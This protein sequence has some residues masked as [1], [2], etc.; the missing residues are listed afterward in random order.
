MVNGTPQKPIE[1][2]SMVYTF[3]KKNANA[4][5]NHKTQYFEMFGNHALYHDGWIICTT[6][7][8]TPW[9][10]TA[11][12]TQDPANA[13]KWELYDLT[14]DWTEYDNIA[15][16]NPEK[17][18]DLQEM[19]WV[20]AAKYQVL[21]LD[22]SKSARLLTPRPSADAGRTDYNYTGVI[23]GIPPSNAPDILNK[24]YTITADFEV[25]NEGGEGMLIRLGGRF[26]GWAL[27][28]LK[29][30]P[31]FL[32]NYVDLDRTRWEGKDSLAPGKHTLVFDFKYDGGGLGK[33]GLGVL[34][35]DGKE[36][37]N[38]R[39]ERSVPYTFNLD[40]DMDIGA[41]LAESISN[42]F[43]AP[44]RFNGKINKVNVKLIPAEPLGK[45]DQK[46]VADANKKIADATE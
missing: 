37:A 26:G 45:D 19:F 15:A 3:D 14:K 35:V 25:P 18:K 31:V 8:N 39:M 46:K 34:K 32:Y 23:T 17:L 1:G 6:P 10:V 30:K 43:K 2:F 20:E 40:E 29:G 24:S 44:F 28:L 16:K 9:D 41:S 42:D 13:F 4:P 33:G 22:A 5:S 11:E 21:P 36:V 12:G 7:L 27:Y 38:H